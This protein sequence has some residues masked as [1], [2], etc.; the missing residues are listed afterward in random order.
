MLFGIAVD[1]AHHFKRPGDPTAAG[2]GRGWVYVH[3][4]PLEPKAI[5]EALDR[6]EFYASTG[7][8]LSEYAASDEG[9]SR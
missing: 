8:E 2:P 4:P 1:D 5:V 7:V 6:G 9:T 3:A